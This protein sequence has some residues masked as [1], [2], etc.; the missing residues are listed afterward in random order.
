M[1]HKCHNDWVGHKIK[2]FFNSI[3]ILCFSVWPLLWLWVV[4]YCCAW[5]HPMTHSV[6]LLWT[7]DRTVAEASTSPHTT[8]TRKRH[9]CPLRDSNPQSHKAILFRFPTD[10]LF[11]TYNTAYIY[12]FHVFSTLRL[13][14]SFEISTFRKTCLWKQ[15]I[16][17]FAGQSS[18][19]W[20]TCTLRLLTPNAAVDGR[21]YFQVKCPFLYLSGTALSFLPINC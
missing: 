16:P 21:T 15:N 9:P 11:K 19:W 7:R 1:H 13:T 14:N 5:P 3:N 17:S 10:S 4:S 8:F 12:F 18:T 6:D 20:L 2:F